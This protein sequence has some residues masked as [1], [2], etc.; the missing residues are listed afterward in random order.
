[1][2]PPRPGSAALKTDTAAQQDGLAAICA[3]GLATRLCAPFQ[4]KLAGFDS[5]SATSA[6]KAPNPLAG[7]DPAPTEG[8][9]GSFTCSWWRK[10]DK[11]H[12]LGMVQRIREFA[13]GKADN[14]TKAIGYGAGMS[15]GRAAN[16]FEDRCSTFQTGPYALYKL[17]GAAAPFAALTN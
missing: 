17:Y 8:P 15:D 7:V 10:A 5:K 14:G 12:R 2:T 9:L 4:A 6:E 3:S 1:M 13:T 16:L 11:E